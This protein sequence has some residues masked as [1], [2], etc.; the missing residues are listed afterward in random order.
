MAK[1]PVCAIRRDVPTGVSF[2]YRVIVR[3]FSS[4]EVMHKFLN[5]QDNNNWSIMTN[6]VKSGK[7]I[8]RGINPAELINVK[9]IDPTALVHM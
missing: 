1:K 5:A 2:K 4:T 7:Y 6:P 9:D 8:E 3:A